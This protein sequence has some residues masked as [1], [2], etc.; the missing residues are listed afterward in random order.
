MCMRAHHASTQ[1]LTCMHVRFPAFFP[2]GLTR[3][4]RSP[5]STAAPQT[6]QPSWRSS[7]PCSRTC[8]HTPQQVRHSKRFGAV[9]FSIGVLCQTNAG[10]LRKDM[11][12][13]PTA[14]GAF[15]RYVCWKGHSA[16]C[17]GQQRGQHSGPQVP[18][19]VGENLADAAAYRMQGVL[20]EAHVTYTVRAYV[21]YAC[22]PYVNTLYTTCLRKQKHHNG[23]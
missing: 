1:S 11:C 8:T 18:S 3:D 6:M 9:A 17:A 23:P 13:H 16:G 19:V 20:P 15:S 4:L 2:A 22:I 14:G 5:A 21:P 12:T 7:L 10:S